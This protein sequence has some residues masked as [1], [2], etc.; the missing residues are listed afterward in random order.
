MCQYLL[1]ICRHLSKHILCCH[2]I[3]VG[4]QLLAYPT[5]L[6]MHPTSAAVVQSQYFP[7]CFV[8]KAVIENFGYGVSAWNIAFFKSSRTDF[9]NIALLSFP[10]SSPPPRKKKTKP[11]NLKQPTNG[12]CAI[13]FRCSFACYGRCAWICGRGSCC[14]NLPCASTGECSM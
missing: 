12:N 4:P 9:K 8:L 14:Y 2:G 3:A 1:I 11:Q 5:C 10:A 13:C 6:I 7:R